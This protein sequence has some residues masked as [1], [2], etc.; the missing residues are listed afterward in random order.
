MAS[1]ACLILFYGN[2]VSLLPL[3]SAIRLCHHGLRARM[4]ISVTS[5]LPVP[6][7]MP[8]LIHPILACRLVTEVPH[9]RIVKLH[10]Y[11]HAAS[12]RVVRYQEH[13]KVVT[14]VVSLSF[15][16]IGC[17]FFLSNCC[18]INLLGNPLLITVLLI[19]DFSFSLSVDVVHIISALC[20][21]QLMIL[22]F[23]RVGVRRFVMKVFVGVNI[24]Y[25][26]ITKNV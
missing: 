18:S 21:R 13:T 22:V 2:R 5:P 16:S 26:Y 20:L 12:C 11:R 8:T 14:L 23:D 9:I 15:L 24:Y 7:I 6:P 17:F 10:L 3:K 25:M 4:L 19:C 1:N